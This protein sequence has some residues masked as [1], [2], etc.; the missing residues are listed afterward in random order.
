MNADLPRPGCGGNKREGRR[1]SDRACDWKVA[2]RREIPLDPFTADVYIATNSL[3]ADPRGTN[4]GPDG[5][6]EVDA[7]TLLES[8][9]VFTHL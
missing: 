6:P 2:R 3:T 5:Q 1:A 4:H 8:I 7:E 9:S